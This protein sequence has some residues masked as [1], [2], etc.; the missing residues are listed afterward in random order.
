MVL[1]SSSL[2]VWLLFCGDA[3][4]SHQQLD[5]SF[6]LLSLNQLERAFATDNQLRI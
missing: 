2:M 5:R 4:Y 3:Y 1:L 6:H